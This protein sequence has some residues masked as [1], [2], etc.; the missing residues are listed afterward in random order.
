MLTHYLKSAWRNL[1]RKR[2]Y[3]LINIAGLALGLASTWLIALYIIDELSYDRFNEKSERIFRVVQHSRWNNNEVHLAITSGPFA[4]ALK[5][6]FPEI[7]DAVRIDREGGGVISFGDK[8]I[9]QGDV[10]FAD[11]S[12]LNVFSYN[13][14]SGNHTA[15]ENP[16]SVVI[17][18]SLARKLFGTAEK[19]FK[20]V[21]YFDTRFPATITGVIKDIPHNSH[22]RFSAVRAAS[23]DYF[24]ENWQNFGIYTYLLLKEGTNINRLREKLSV[25]A[26]TTIQKQV[27]V[28]DY[29]MELQTVTSIHLHSNLG[30][31]LS[32]NGNASRVYIFIAIALLILVIAIINYTNLTTARASA[33]IKEIGVRKAIGSGKNNLAGIFI[34]EALLVTFIAACVAIVI[35]NFSLPFFNQ[36]TEKDL[37]LDQPGVLTTTATLLVF[38]VLTGFISGIYPSVFLAGFKTIPALKGQ[39][40]N[41]SGNILFR[42]SLVVFQFVITIMM[43]A[44]SIIIYQQ[45]HFAKSTSLGFNKDQVLTFHIDDQEVRKQVGALKTQLLRNS[46]IEGVAAAGNPIGNNNL[47]GMGYRFETPQGG[48]STATTLAQELTVDKDFLPTLGITLSQGRNF[49]SQFTTDKDGAALINESLMKKLGW[50]N[51]VGK[52]MQFTVDDNSAPLVRTIVGVVKDFHT[53]SLQHKIEPLVMVMPA[54]PNSEDNIYVKIAKG[55]I[56]D[57]LAFI[58]KTFGEFDK[59]GDAELNF[60]DENFAKQYEAEERQGKL[61]LVFAILAIFI[62][63]LGLFG[64]A[65]FTTVQRTRE[66]GIRK[67]MGAS[68]T[69]IMQLLSSDFMKLLVLSAAIALPVAWIAMNKW[70]QGFAYHIDIKWWVLLLAGILAFFVALIPVSLQAISA[71]VANPVKSLRSE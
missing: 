9:K 1:V 64:L 69:D 50:N 14:L 29:S 68:I 40:G 55:K 59:T 30:F 31:E 12:L 28:D 61:A 32:P 67:A 41:M 38:S 7:E 53:Y 36:L 58:K 3:S 60:L 42:R 22:L 8:K 17:T 19:A 63:S 54:S 43:I 52:R 18:E 48:F 56:P 47:G 51:A 27:K 16:E 66:I 62:A 2:T 15:L 21:I 4:P 65:A 20:Q 6:A 37:S 5:A 23:D 35:V 25:F 71:A 57:G 11:K 10:I 24:G 13:F 39:L 45:L 33:R 46:D 44:S 26:N 70:L 49:S 34:T